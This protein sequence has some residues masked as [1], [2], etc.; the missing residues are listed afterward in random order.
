MNA[1]RRP[2]RKWRGSGARPGSSGDLPPRAPGAGATTCCCQLGVLD[3]GSSLD[4]RPRLP[5]LSWPNWAVRDLWILGSIPPALSCDSPSLRVPAP[6]HTSETV[7][8]RQLGSPRWD[9]EVRRDR[10]SWD[11]WRSPSEGLPQWSGVRDDWGGRSVRGA[12]ARGLFVLRATRKDYLGP[13]EYFSW[14]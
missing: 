5:Q 11:G 9:Q 7:P 6:A 12:G 14:G 10:D 8:H 13:G 4:P 2:M 1:L 3:E